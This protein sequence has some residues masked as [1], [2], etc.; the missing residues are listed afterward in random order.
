MLF[1]RVA[2]A[3]RA[4]FGFF[5]AEFALRLSTA[6]LLTYVSVLL[7]RIVGELIGA[8]TVEFDCG[9]CVS[10]LCSKFLLLLLTRVMIRDMTINHIGIVM[11]LRVGVLTIELCCCRSR[12]LVR[13]RYAVITVCFLPLRPALR[14]VALGEFRPFR[15]GDGLLFYG[16]FS[17]CR[18]E[19]HIAHINGI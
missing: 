8:I 9:F 14:A 17:G 19:F 4:S 11:R 12:G 13:C 2:A 15:L 7:Q 16:L 5:T 18:P 10:K 6:L 3:L 1:W